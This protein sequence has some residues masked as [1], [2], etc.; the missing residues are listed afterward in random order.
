MESRLTVQ[1]TSVFS[2]IKV[3]FLLILKGGVKNV[4]SIKAATNQKPGFDIEETSNTCPYMHARTTEIQNAPA[5]EYGVAFDN[6]LWVNSC[7]KIA[8]ANPL[9][10]T[11][12]SS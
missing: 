3:W 10:F 7:T 8:Y 4:R 11:V 12:F 9:K 1:T 5:M 2:I 6:T